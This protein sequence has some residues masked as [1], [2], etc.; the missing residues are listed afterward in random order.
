MLLISD[1]SASPQVTGHSKGFCNSNNNINFFI[2][3][4]DDNNKYI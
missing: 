4:L 1:P 2:F 3:Y